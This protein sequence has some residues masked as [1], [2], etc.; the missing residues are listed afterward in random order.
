MGCFGTSGFLSRLPILSGQRVVCFIASVHSDTS[1]RGTYYPD[2]VVAPYCLPIHGE[3][4]D[5]GCIEN[6]VRDANV[7]VIEKYFGCEINK[8][9]K[10]IERLLYGKT[11]K[12]NIRYW[13]KDEDDW[14]KQ[15]AQQY[16][17]IVPLENGLDELGFNKNRTY[18]WTLLFEHE[19]IYNNV[20]EMYG[21]DK[22]EDC[23]NN[24][25]NTFI[26]V[27]KRYKEL[28]NKYKNSEVYDAKFEH[29]FLEDIPNMFKR[30]YFGSSI[31]CFSDYLEDLLDGDIGDA[32]KEKIKEMIDMS[33]EIG[34]IYND[35][36]RNILYLNHEGTSESFMAIFKQVD[37]DSCFKLYLDCEDEIRKFYSIWWFC[38]SIPMHFGLSHT[39]S[40][41]YDENDFKK[42]NA[43]INNVIDN[44][45][46][47]DNP[48]K[49][50]NETYFLIGHEL[51]NGEVEFQRNTLGGYDFSPIIDNETCYWKTREAAYGE[52][53]RL[54][55]EGDNNCLMWKITKTT[56]V[57]PIDY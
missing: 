6:I 4:D 53:D 30:K 15:E 10:G 13:S 16:K 7:E 48:S 47:N 23:C 52:I 12:E 45:F 14:H 2:S 3:Y 21:P 28:Y 55:S 34:K 27:T 49:E 36:R 17:N 18:Q 24:A 41:E 40:Q 11:I 26:D 22:L 32:K 33:H 38:N 29:F 37:I 51:E 9:L 5:Y 50:T 57:T 35:S 39:G 42:F 54:E 19:D 46:F 43:I 20:A 56:K 1:I 25:I 31:G 44:E 8:V